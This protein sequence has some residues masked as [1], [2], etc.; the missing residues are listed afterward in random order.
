VAFIVFGGPEEPQ[1]GNHDGSQE[2]IGVF[3][4]L[5]EVRSSRLP[6]V[7]GVLAWLLG[8]CEGE[9]VG[10]RAGSLKLSRYDETFTPMVLVALIFVFS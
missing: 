1:I 9:P 7:V 3:A 2:D 5:R 8:W 6:D 4:P 10:L